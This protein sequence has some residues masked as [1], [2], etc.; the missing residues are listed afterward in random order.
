[1]VDD[2]NRSWI[3]EPAS[4]AVY[5]N[6]TRLFAYLALRRSLTCKELALALNEI[7][8]AADYLKGTLPARTRE[9]LVRVRELNTQINGELRAEHTERCPSDPASPTQ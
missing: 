1:M 7:R 5:A 2:P 3:Q 8:A 4:P 9:Q 6:G